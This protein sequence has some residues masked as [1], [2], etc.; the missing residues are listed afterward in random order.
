MITSLL[1]PAPAAR[2]ATAYAVSRNPTT[3]GP[4]CGV[5][6]SVT[7][8]GD[9][10]VSGSRV[11]VT[12]AAERPTRLAAAEKAIAGQKAGEAAAAAAGAAAAAETAARGD[13]SPQRSTASI[14]PAC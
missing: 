12:G 10:A 7:L 5:V 13:R 8:G 9:G 1:L 11:A 2:T 6:A 3:L 14:S 4:I